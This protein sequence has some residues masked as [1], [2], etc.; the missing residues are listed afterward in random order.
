MIYVR[1]RVQNRG[2]GIAKT[3]QVYLISLK[4]VLPGGNIVPTALDD[5]KALAWAGW[6]FSPMD[7]PPGATCYADVVR[8]SKDDSGWLFSV[9]QLFASQ[10]ELKNYRGTYRFTVMVV[11]DN[12][13][14][15][16]CEFDVTYNGDWHSLR[17]VPVTN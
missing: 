6:K 10:Q 7:V 13:S 8:V 11:G 1:V 5:S 3:C 14:K 16:S 9:E 12:A 15:S 2:T 4:E 17:A